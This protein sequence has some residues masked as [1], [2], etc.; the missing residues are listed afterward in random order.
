MVDVVGEAHA[1]RRGRR[2]A[3]SR[4][5]R[6]RPSP[7]P[8]LKSYCA[9][10]SVRS[11][12]VE[13]RRDARARSPPAAGRRPSEC[14]SRCAR[15]STGSPLPGSGRPRT[16]TGTARAPLCAARGSPRYLEARADAPLLLVGEAPGYRGARISGIPFTSERQLTGSRARGGDRDDRPPGARRARARR[17]GAALERRSDP[18]RHRD[19]RTARPTAA[20]VAAGLAFAQ[21]L[22]RGPPGASPSGGSPRPLWEPNTSA[23]RPTAGWPNSGRGCYDSRPG[24]RPCPPV[25]LGTC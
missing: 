7:A 9:R 8:S 19:A 13:E 24:G 15:S 3:G 16:S 23:I 11:R 14:G 21:E 25:L 2:R 10:S 12:P 4:R 22:A 5:R 20:E 1:R 18:S 17:A 6:S